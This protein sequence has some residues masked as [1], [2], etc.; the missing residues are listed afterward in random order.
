MRCTSTGVAALQHRT[1]YLLAGVG[2]TLQAA[3]A[4]GTGFHD[5]WNAVGVCGL[6]PAAE[7]LLK[8]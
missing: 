2:Q 7:S 6:C 3:L 1:A 5:A 4:S 8:V